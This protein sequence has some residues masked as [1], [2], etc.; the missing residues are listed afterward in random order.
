MSSVTTHS[1]R[2]R[3]SQLETRLDR[4]EKIGTTV[5][6][7][8]PSTSQS[9]PQSLWLT[10]ILQGVTL[11]TIAACAFWLGSMSSTVSST[12]TK[13]D[14]LSDAVVGTSKDSLNSR[15]AVMETKLDG[16]NSKLDRLEPS[17]R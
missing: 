6:Q 15:M 8:T 16:M 4:L 9:P 10:N 17:A 3:L 14:K 5:V 7:A 2:E 12:S 1:E 13:V 11:V